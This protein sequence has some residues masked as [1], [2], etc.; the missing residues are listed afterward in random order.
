M[1]DAISE[2]HDVA[3]F[4]GA[5]FT[6]SVAEGFKWTEN[7][8]EPSWRSLEL[9]PGN[10]PRFSEQARTL[11][12]RGNDTWT[13]ENWVTGAPIRSD[14][15]ANDVP[16]VFQNGLKLTPAESRWGQFGVRVERNKLAEC[17]IPSISSQNGA[18]PSVP[19]VISH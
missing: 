2:L 6:A 13:L 1:A 8:L 10:R 9:D 11:I 3:F 17:A 7:A 4:R 19:T 16:V 14:S 18:S 15:I 12:L 5:V